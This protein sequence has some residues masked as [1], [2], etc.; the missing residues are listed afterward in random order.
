MAKPWYCYTRRGN[1]HACSRHC[2]SRWEG[3]SFSFLGQFLRLLS[4]FID[5]PPVFYPNLFIRLNEFDILKVI[6]AVG[7]DAPYSKNF[8]VFRI[9]DKILMTIDALP[10]GLLCL[11]VLFHY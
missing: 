8:F 7:M 6:F 4:R 1:G 9:H 10:F 2:Y 3:F 5:T 11:T